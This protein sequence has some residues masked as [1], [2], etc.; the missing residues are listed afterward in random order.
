MILGEIDRKEVV[1]YLGYRGHVPDKTIMGL[2]EECV[3][4]LGQVAMPKY[5][6]RRFEIERNENSVVIGNLSMNSKSLSKNLKD[7]REVLSFAAT[8]GMGSDLLLK[9]NIRLQITKATVLQAVGAAAIEAFCDQCQKKF[10]KDLLRENLFL[11]PRY[12]PGYGDLNLNVQ[13]DFL[14][15]LNASKQIGIYLTDGGVMVPEKT[16]TAI[17]G[18]GPKNMNCNLEGCEVCTQKNCEYKRYV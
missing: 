7:C 13:K 5:L 12:S 3:T 16:V 9:K 17:M 4:E 6:V 15:L 2:I 14:E 11:R 18:I 10:E 8:L 1:R